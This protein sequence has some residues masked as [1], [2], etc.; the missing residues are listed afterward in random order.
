M[1]PL[2][3]A[4]TNYKQSKFHLELEKL[5]IYNANTH[6]PP[7][8]CAQGQSSAKPNRYCYLYGAGNLLYKRVQYWLVIL[9]FCSWHSGLS[10]LACALEDVT[11]STQRESMVVSSHQLRHSGPC[12]SHSPVFITNLRRLTDD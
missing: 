3:E 4:L 6:P 10:L 9:V 7:F 11:L 5:C 8:I 2:M 12:A 1:F